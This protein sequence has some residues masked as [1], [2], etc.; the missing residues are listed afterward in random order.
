MKTQPYASYQQV[1]SIVVQLNLKTPGGGGAVNDYDEICSQSNLHENES[2][3]DDSNLATSAKK[4]P[5][6]M[7]GEDNLETPARR[8]SRQESNL[9]RRIYDA[10]N[11]LKAASIIVEYD[12]KHFMYNPS[13]LHEMDSH[14]QHSE[15]NINDDQPDEHLQM[16]G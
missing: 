3:W 1:A 2:C 14:G 8:R 5:F 6:T 4:R 9:R 10:W 7:V 16:T 11:V 15:E 12:D 13:V